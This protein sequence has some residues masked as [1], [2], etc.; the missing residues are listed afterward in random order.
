M[1]YAKEGRM[2]SICKHCWWINKHIII[3]VT[4]I[5]SLQLQFFSFSF[6]V[7][8]IHLRDSA[9]ISGRAL[10][11]PEI[12]NLPSTI[13]RRIKLDLSAKKKEII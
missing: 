5:F 6:K 2:E 11:K 9:N 10:H 4:A 3:L 1:D 8:Q 7:F 13:L 12:I